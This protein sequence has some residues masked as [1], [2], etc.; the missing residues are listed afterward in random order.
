MC[1]SVALTPLYYCAA[2]PTIYFRIS[3]YLAKLKL[4]QLKNNSPSSF[5]Q[6]V[7]SILALSGS[8]KFDCF[9]YLM[10]VKFIQYVSFCVWLISF[11]T[12][13]SEFLHVTCQ[14][15]LPF[16]AEKYPSHVYP[17]VCLSIHLSVDSWV[18][19]AFWLLWIMLLLSEMYK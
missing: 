4:C 17:T 15:F 3:F 18:A 19:S 5:H 12:V 9:R 1:S 8:I 10:W 2:I 6:P 7:A 16:K 13:S 11:S 14:N